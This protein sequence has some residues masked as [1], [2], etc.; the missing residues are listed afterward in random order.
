[1]K[2]IIVLIAI[3][4]SSLGFSQVNSPGDFPNDNPDPASIPNAPT[5]PTRNAWDVIS[6][7][8]DA[9]A[10]VSNVDYYPNWGQ[11]TTFEVN[12]DLG[13]PK[14]HYSNLDYQGISFTEIN[15]SSMTKLHLDIWTSNIT[16]F[17][18]YLIG[19]GENGV[20]LTP[21]LSGWN[22]YD[23]DLSTF[24]G[25]N[26][27]AIFQIKLEKPGFSYHGESN[28]IYIDNIYFWKP[29]TSSPPPSLGSF[30]VPAYVVGDSNFE[31]TAPT[32]NSLG[33]FT[34]SSSNTNVATV[35]GSTVTIVGAGTSIITAVQAAQGAFSSGTKTASLVVTSP[36]LPPIPLTPPTVNAPTPPSRNSWDVISV[37]SDAYATNVTTD[38][39]PNW[40]QMGSVN[41]TYKPIESENNYAMVYTNFNYQ[42]TNLSTQNASS[43]EYLHMDIW[44]SNA[45]VVKV[46]PINN[47]TGA[48][49][50]LVNIPLVI[51]GWSSIDLPKSAF[52]GMTWD[53]VFQMK[54][55]GQSGVTPS[56]IYLDNI[57]FWKPTT[58]SPP[59]T[60]GSFS[61]P[62]HVIGD[63][64]F[65]LIAPTSNSLGQFTFSS[66]N[67]NVATVSGSTVTIVGAGTSIITAVQAAQGAFSSGTKTASLVVTSPPLPPIPLT[68]PTVNA[69]TP[70]SRNS[71]DV[72]SVYS[73]AYATNVTTDYNPNWGQMGSVNTTYKP[74]E[75]ENNYAMVYTNFNYQGTNLSTQNASSMEYLHMDI[76]TSNATVVKV[77]PI[78]NGTGAMEF[79]VNIPLV[80][81]GWSSIDLPKSAFVGMTW[82]NIFQMKYDGTSG[83]QN[84]TIY[85]DNIYFWKSSTIIQNLCTKALKPYNVN[86]G[87]ALHNGSTY[88][89]SLSPA[90]P[91]VVISGNGTNAITIDWTNVPDGSYTLQAIE[92]SVTGCVSTAVTAVINLYATPVPV[93]Q[94]QT[95][96]T[97]ATVA[98]LVATGTNLQWYANPTGGAALD[99]IAILTTGTYYV[100]Q[101]LGTCESTRISVV[102]TVIP[103]ITPAFT[104]IASSC[105]GATITEFP[106]TSNNG[107]TGTW[108]PA[109]NNNVTTNYTF[110]PNEGQCAATTTQTITITTPKVTSPISFVAP[111]ATVATLPSIT[112]GTQIWTNKNLDVSTYRDGTP[113]PQVTDPTAWANLTTG[114][115]CYYN[116]DQAN[117]EVYG[118]LYNWYA[119]AG[120]YD[121]A[122]LANASLRKKLA[123]TSWHVPTDT[124]WSSLFNCLDPNS[125]GGANYPNVVGGKMK[126]TGTAHWNSPNTDATN[127]SGFTGL[128]G[129]TRR[130]DN[131]IFQAIGDYGIWWSSSEYVAENPPFGSFAN[132]DSWLLSLYSS[133][134]AAGK[135][136]GY[137]QNGYSVRCL[138]D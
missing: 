51:N 113:I 25:V 28:S 71:W 23:I 32:S 40:G 36:P 22:S 52:V 122:S 44:T 42:G 110:T 43:M 128:P 88:A 37:Y 27:N 90:A 132:T 67:T 114:A 19:G 121:A 55:E 85:L 17:K 24:V 54:F 45:T 31:L 48:M 95:F 4:S 66:S 103:Q 84:S 14:L 16:Q 33:Q 99:S 91:N 93:A 75:S 26:L 104:P 87:D 135:D 68:P 82:D 69:P 65:D 101:T 72:I 115:W 20:T 57:Y 126:E 100:S 112:I 86:V 7:Y 18:F 35:S 89:W 11:G 53:S 56:T 102:V 120:I 108:S 131:G 12:S 138:K 5:Q 41:T 133:Y 3:I 137:N 129:G 64:N 50:F 63:S 106:T 59:P 61:V 117:G 30:S 47:G 21:T 39:N 13:D 97:D 136:I 62:A 116:N 92:T 49:E 2:K 111:P 58:S 83:V 78:N 80:I 29:T 125:N 124:E 70:P 127:S 109:I 6:I 79:L 8:S 46:S 38:Y 1:M 107:I 9:Y 60:L 130:S 76:W 96:C 73:D 77:S 105:S 119:V 134:G 98:N 10:N 118:K 94:S 15:I 81:N 74:I 123:P 34:F